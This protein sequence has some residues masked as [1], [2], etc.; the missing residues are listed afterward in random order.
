MNPSLSAFD[1]AHVEPLLLL[2]SPAQLGSVLPVLDF[3]AVEPSFFSHSF[4]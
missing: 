2:R 4:G 3:G 1:N